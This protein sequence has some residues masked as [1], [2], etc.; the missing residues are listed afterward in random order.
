M[1][2]WQYERRSVRPKIGRTPLQREGELVGGGGEF[3]QT[4]HNIIIR[5][6]INDV[7]NFEMVCTIHILVD[8]F[9][10]L[11]FSTTAPLCIFSHSFTFTAYTPQASH[12]F[13][14]KSTFILS[15]PISYLNAIHHTS[16]LVLKLHG[17]QQA[18][19]PSVF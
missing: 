16:E 10:N 17:G 1:A 11:I 13:S 18:L 2:S 5:H 4:M 8:D 6:N 9:C 12:F 7:T 19:F 14:K 15:L 3:C